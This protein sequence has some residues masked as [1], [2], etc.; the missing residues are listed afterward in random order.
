MPKWTY[1]HDLDPFIIQFTE[2]IG[3]R[4]YSMAYI[5]GFIVGYLLMKM[6]VVRTDSP[7][8]KK[9]LDDFI[10]W[11]AFG[12]ILGGR[13]G[14]AVFYAPEIFIEFNSEFPYWGLIKIH[15]GGLASHGGI[16]GVI[17]ASIL[18]AKKY[19]LSALYSLDLLALSV[20]P[21]VI[22]G[23]I[24]NF[25]NGE[26]YGRVIEGKVLVAVQFPQEMLRWLYHK[27]TDS[28]Q[29]LSHAVSALKPEIHPSMWQD[30]VYQ[31]ES[32]GDYK[33]QVS[34][35]IYALIKACEE[36][37][38]A[39]IVALKEV[40]SFRHPSQIY[41]AILEGLLPFLLV[42]SIWFIWAK[43]KSLRPG[44]LTGVSALCYACMRI[45]GEQFRM[46]D[47]NLG[48]ELLG[49]TRGQWLTCIMLLGI[50]F[51]FVFL[52]FLKSSKF[53]PQKSV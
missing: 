2:A 26:L 35:I 21:G 8:S 19:K 40:L 50:A 3:L 12:V 1:F 42:W 10:I 9:N 15:K 7:F 14:Y 16:I 38:K 36:G 27:K 51:Y 33:H 13:L 31:L 47:T 48:F 45:L 44:V 28:L 39:V 46:P 23:R 43:R 6:I 30:L 17:T 4:W 11:L 34:S 49:L 5:M 20:S 25:I 52:F 24:A 18:F 41:Q 53:K 37:N 29:E 32:T 22:F